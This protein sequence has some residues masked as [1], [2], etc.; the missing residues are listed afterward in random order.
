MPQSPVERTHAARIGVHTSW[1]RTPDRTARTEPAR[2][3][4]EERFIDQVDPDRV[5]SVEERTAR[6]ASARAA[7]MA[8]LSWKAAKARR[9]AIERRAGEL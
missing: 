7:Y 5:L 1:S 8:R 9:L 4:F 3:A 6:A 2:S